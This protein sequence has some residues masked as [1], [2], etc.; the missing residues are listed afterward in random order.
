VDTTTDPSHCGLCGNSCGADQSCDGGRCYCSAG[1]AGDGTELYAGF[2]SKLFWNGTEALVLVER[3]GD[4]DGRELWAHRF[5]AEGA[6][7]GIPVRIAR[8]PNVNVDQVYPV[9]AAWNGTSWG[10]LVRSRVIDG[11]YSVH[12]YPLN[13]DGVAPAIE[14]FAGRSTSRSDQQWAASRVFADGGVWHVFGARNHAGFVSTTDALLLQSVTDGAAGSVRTVVPSSTNYALAQ[15]P[16]GF[17]LSHVST[18]GATSVVA[19]DRSG[20]AVASL[21]NIPSGRPPGRQVLV[22]GTGR[23]LLVQHVATSP[24][25]IYTRMLPS[26]AERAIPDLTRPLE[27]RFSWGPN[28]VVINN[29]E[30]LSFTNIRRYEVTS[31]GLVRRDAMTVVGALYPD[32]IQHVQTGMDR[33]LVMV[34]DGTNVRLHPVRFSECP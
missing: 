14:L 24:T 3:R 1:S 15:T 27:T 4:P 7:V 8:S 12:L 2:Q 30:D 10:V 18:A 28:G 34:R 13:A 26:W 9:D 22:D 20:N 29:V 19:L 11:V 5:D 21:A 31:E 17:I 23:W 33:A 16:T 32:D 6:P 25:T